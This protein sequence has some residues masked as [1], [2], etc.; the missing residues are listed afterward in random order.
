[1]VFRSSC[2]AD[3]F[4]RADTSKKWS[5]EQGEKHARP[6][7]AAHSILPAASR[8]AWENVAIGASRRGDPVANRP[9]V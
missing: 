7:R 5:A 4:L 2:V 3:D 1:M 8:L 9:R 6:D